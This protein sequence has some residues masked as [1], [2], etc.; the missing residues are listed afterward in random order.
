[1]K[2]VHVSAAVIIKD[3]KILCVQRNSN[4]FDYISNK[5]EFPG[6]KIEENELSEE[7]IKRE[8]K[9]ELSLTIKVNGFLVQVD[10]LYPDFRIIMDTFLCEIVSGEIQLNEHIDLKWLS[11]SELP[12]LDWAAADLPIVKSLIE[13]EN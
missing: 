6:G 7:T 2:T 9:E 3:K 11:K 10:Y 5:W 13:Q 12:Y 1:M 4:K 8:I